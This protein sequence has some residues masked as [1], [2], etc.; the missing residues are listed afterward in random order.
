MYLDDGIAG[1]NSYESLIQSRNMMLTDLDSAGLTVNFEKSSL[2]PERRKTW[3]GFIID[4]IDMIFE[5]PTSKVERVLGLIS[6][7]LNNDFLSAREISKI[8]GNLISMATAV[9]P[10]VYLLTKQMYKFV[11]SSFSWDKRRLLNF[12]VRQELEFWF[13]NLLHSKT[14]RIKTKPEITK[15][16]YSD[17]S[18]TGYGGYIVEKLGNVIAKGDF[19]HFE[20]KTSS[21]YRELLAVKYVLQS[22]TEALQNETIEWFTDNDNVCKIVNRGS[23]RQHLQTLAI[24]IFSICISQNIEIYPTWIPRELNETA[25]IISK[26][27]DT[28]NWSIDNE[29]FNY[30]IKNYGEDFYRQ[31]FG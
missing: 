31:I 20:T 24:E 30:I 19:N 5:V 12:D 13:K 26:S 25:D 23:T 28:D 3:L 4:T 22:F 6:E 16:V 11:E 8:A 14:F 9:G 18:A 29:T 17:A 7:A 1:D 15:I 10:L 21:T 2:E 27:I